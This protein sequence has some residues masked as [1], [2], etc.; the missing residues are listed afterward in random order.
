MRAMP[1]LVPGN[2]LQ[3]SSD[4][5]VGAITVF[6]PRGAK[7][8]IR[9]LRMPIGRFRSRSRRF[10]SIQHAVD[11]QRL[12][13][14][15]ALKAFFLKVLLLPQIR[16]QGWYSPL[17]RMKNGLPRSKERLW[18]KVSKVWLRWNPL[19]GIPSQR[20]GNILLKDTIEKQPF[21]VGYR[22]YTAF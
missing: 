15:G 6:L 19:A 22:K 10:W 1:D 9:R 5:I 18:S 21:Q 13:K 16:W 20:I 12:C 14:P 2:A 7:I 4:Q 11:P 17:A 8:G 3:S